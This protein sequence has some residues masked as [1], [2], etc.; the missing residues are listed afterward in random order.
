MTRMAADRISPERHGAPADVEAIIL[1]A[2]RGSRLAARTARP[3]CLVEIGGVPLIEHQLRMLEMVG[4]S[5]VLVVAGYRADDVRGAV[6]GRARVIENEAWSNTNSLYSLALCRPHVSCSMVVMNCDV[7]VHPLAFQRLLHA[8]G[9]A[10]LYDSAS[11]DDAEQMKVELRGGCLNA[12]S[13]TLPAHRTHGENV[14]S[15]YFEAAA[16][17][18]LLRVASDLVAQGQGNSWMASAV[19]RVARS[20][21]LHGIDISDLPWI[22]I[23]FPDDL[24]R[25]CTQ[26]WRR[27]AGALTPA[28]QLAG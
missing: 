6:R 14:G 25:A 21:P 3:K 27:V 19:E 18:E 10:F 17:Q 7:L 15:L 9:S 11:G 20:R 16:A 8:P 12:M 22:E 2:G 13:K 4:I 24:E 5:R 26:V 1:A 28:M 23:D